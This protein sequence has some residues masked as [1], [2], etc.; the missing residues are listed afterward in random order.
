MYRHYPSQVDDQ[1]NFLWHITDINDARQYGE[2]WVDVAWAASAI[3]IPGG[4]KY[5]VTYTGAQ[6]LN[7][8]TVTGLQNDGAL[9]KLCAD[10]T[11][12]GGSLTIQHN[13][14][15][16]RTISGVNI[17]LN[18]D[19]WIAEFTRMPSGNIIVGNVISY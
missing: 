1:T 11:G 9:G 13:V 2:T 8:I 3:S 17:L 6:V 14:G 19:D 5:R 18:G 7:T 10:V 16:I 4:G 12:A 15:N